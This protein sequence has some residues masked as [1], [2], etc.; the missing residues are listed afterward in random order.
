ML[1][2]RNTSKT[3]KP[4]QDSKLEVLKAIQLAIIPTLRNAD[5]GH[6]VIHLYR[7]ISNRSPALFNDNCNGAF[8]RTVMMLVTVAINADCVGRRRP[9]PSSK[10]RTVR[11]AANQRVKIMRSRE[12]QNQL[13]E[14]CLLT[15]VARRTLSPARSKYREM[16]SFVTGLA[17]T[18]RSNAR[19]PKET[20][21]RNGRW[22]KTKKEICSVNVLLALFRR[23]YYKK[24][25]TVS[26]T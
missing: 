26:Y 25:G 17:S 21:K 10:Q 16:C 3:H 9:P 11:P 6:T 19:C 5:H 13:P 15:C 23:F 8:I 1:K 18:T 20:E 7:S 14:T 22:K 12:F 24:R 2:L 4:S